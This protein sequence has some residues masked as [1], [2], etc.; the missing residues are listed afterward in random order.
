MKIIR[1]IFVALVAFFLVELYIDSNMM[2]VTDISIKD[3]KIPES[4]DGYKILH[5]SDLH[6]KSFGDKNINLVNKVNEIN[7][8]VIVMTGD[9]VNCNDTNFDNFFNLAKALSQKYKIY[10]I[11]GNHEQ[12]MKEESKKT[13]M[14]FL[15]A[16]GIEILDN[17]KT[18]LEENGETINLYGSWCNLRYYSAKDSGEK[19]DFTVDVMKKIMENAPMEEDEYNILLA[20]NPNFIDA[21]AKWGADLTLSGH[22]HGG[23]V[24][25]PF[26]GGVFSPDTVL[27]PKYSSGLYEV[28]G[29]KLIVSRG[30][31]RGVRGFRFFNRPEMVLITLNSETNEN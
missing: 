4:F 30:L 23:M 12:N 13:I 17:E 22:I 14:D 11:V 9:M 25:I 16:N 26:L 15:K 7:P 31:G 2:V 18:V 8:N 19:Y 27:F 28:E 29:K 10:Y 3:K 21:Y 24:R 6:S 1:K 5:L 20:H